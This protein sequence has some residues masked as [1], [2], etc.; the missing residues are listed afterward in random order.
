MSLPTGLYRIVNVDS[1]EDVALPDSNDRSNVVV[2]D[3][4]DDDETNANL[5]C[6]VMHRWP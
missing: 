3:G 5:V 2:H 1:E 4:D 6:L